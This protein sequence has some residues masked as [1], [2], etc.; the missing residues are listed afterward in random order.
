MIDIDQ[1][2]PGNPGQQHR[3]HLGDVRVADSEIRE[4]R[5]DRHQ[6]D[7]AGTAAVTTCADIGT[8]NPPSTRYAATSC[9]TAARMRSSRSGGC[10][11]R[12]AAVRTAASRWTSTR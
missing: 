3:L 11:R 4:Q 5:D 7:A 6:A 2:G 9:A 12:A 1:R 10:W 8:A